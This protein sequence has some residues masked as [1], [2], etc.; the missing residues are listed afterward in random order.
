MPLWALS[1]DSFLMTHFSEQ[2]QASCFRIT[3]ISGDKNINQIIFF[4]LYFPFYQAFLELSEVAV[5]EFSEI[6]RKLLGKNRV[7]ES[8]VNDVK[9]SASSRAFL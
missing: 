6:F 4:V 3:F 2:L 7:L 9:F 5:H 1:A 8:M